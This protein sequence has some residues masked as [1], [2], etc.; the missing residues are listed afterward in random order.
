MSAQSVLVTL[1]ATL[2]LSGCAGAYAPETALVQIRDGGYP[3]GGPV[4]GIFEPATLVIA[5]GTEVRWRND[6]AQ[7]H[8]V[9]TQDAGLAEL[10][11]VPGGAEPWDSGP[12]WPGDTFAHRFE[13]EGIYIYWCTNHQEEQM[14]GTIRVEQP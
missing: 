14:I 6:G 3:S 8:T 1:A 4:P 13:T 2:A 12:L 7:M 9:T 11:A 5:P 10:P